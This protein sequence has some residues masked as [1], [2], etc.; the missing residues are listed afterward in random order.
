[1]NLPP[2]HCPASGVQLQIAGESLVGAGCRYPLAFGVPIV[3]EGVE[4][5]QAPPPA[6]C[7]LTQLADALSNKVTVDEL[8]R[9]FSVRF[10]FRESWLQAEADQFIS[11]VADSHAGLASCI[12]RAVP[13][14]ATVVNEEP[15][16]RISTQFK[17]D[18]MAPNEVTSINVRV[19]NLGSCRVSSDGAQP[20]MLAYL[21][22]HGERLV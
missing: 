15:A 19:T 18:H 10:R 21:W 1:M 7:V 20:V 5:E 22:K 14:A 4:L 16:L 8:R 17:L 11:R 2:L 3:I 9:V 12:D 6:D 13:S